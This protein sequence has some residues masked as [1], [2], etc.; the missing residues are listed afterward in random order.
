M[1]SIIFEYSKRFNLVSFESRNYSKGMPKYLVIWE[2][3]KA[4]M[5]EVIHFFKH[6]DIM[7]IY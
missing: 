6:V 2:S 3:F 7:L 4:I 5:I 1:V